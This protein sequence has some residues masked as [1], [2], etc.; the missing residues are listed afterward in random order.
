MNVLL[1]FIG[2]RHVNDIWQFLNVNASGNGIS[3]NQETDISFLESL[4]CSD[5]SVRPYNTNQH[6]N[7]GEQQQQQQMAA[8]SGPSLG[9]QQSRHPTLRL[10]FR[11]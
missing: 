2:Q 5:A 4:Q 11:S 8:V 6:R 10:A 9:G 7:T 1:W 3:A